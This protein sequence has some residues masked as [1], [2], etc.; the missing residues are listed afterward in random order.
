M[1]FLYH[2]RLVTMGMT[3]SISYAWM[4]PRAYG[5]IMGINLIF[6]FSVGLC[7]INC[8]TVGAICG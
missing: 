8:H 4:S 1:F 7:G 5:N 6:P 2:V 3:K